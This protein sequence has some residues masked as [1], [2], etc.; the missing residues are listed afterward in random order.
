MSETRNNNLRKG[1][2]MKTKLLASTLLT[3]SLAGAGQ[4]A[5]NDYTAHEW[6]TF[7]YVQGADGIPVQWRPLETS[8]LPKFVYTR[9]NVSGLRFDDYL[10]KRNLMSL[11][12]METPVIYF[13]SDAELKVN[14]RVDFPNG[15]VTEW[16]PAVQEFGP[17]MTPV[18]P[19]PGAV[20]ESLIRWN[21]VTVLPKDSPAKALA[22]DRS[23][24]HYFAARETDANV[25]RIEG[26]TGP[27]DEKFLFYRGVGNFAPPLQVSLGG[28]ERQLSMANNGRET[29]AR[30]FVLSVR[31]DKARLTSLDAIEPGKMRAATLTTPDEPLNKVAE[32]LGAEMQQ[33]LVSEGL[34][35]RE[36]AAM[37]ETWKNSWFP[38]QGV[39][40]LYTLPP[41]WTD[42]TLPL[43]LDPA[44]HQIARVMVGRA[45]LIT[46]AAERELQQQ[47]TRFSSK[48]AKERDEAVAAVRKL[49]LGRF[50]EPAVRRI[51]GPQPSKELS[52]VAWDLVN[53]AMK[54]V[55][56]KRLA[57][58]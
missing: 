30:L 39:R 36:A 38:E 10:D 35:P 2:I 1:E 4:L 54:P 21:N 6:G 11:V 7:T 19:A 5:A 28:D 56:G 34:F 20:K 16:Y 37:V 41:A 18:M 15:L 25:V 44:P 31:G 26:K 17:F 27:E 8:D 22:D 51:L 50:N 23:G 42:R 47:I 43:K 24:N 29:I 55:E 3:L 46:P 49:G 13:Y 40:V 9:R 52:K 33:A 12:R 14:V 53:T 58:K 32:T 57:K 45:E 48:D